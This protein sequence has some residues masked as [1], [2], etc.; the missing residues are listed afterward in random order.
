M[1]KNLLTTQS[2][3][4]NITLSNKGEKTMY[5]YEEP[6]KP[7]DTISTLTNYFISNKAQI[8]QLET[9]NELIKNRI[10]HLMRT[11][12]PIDFLACTSI[13]M[14][15]S[16]NDYIKKN[17]KRGEDGWKEARAYYKY[18]LDELHKISS[19]IA[20]IKS[21]VQECGYCYSTIAISIVFDLNDNEFELHVPMAKNLTVE[22]VFHDGYINTHANEFQLY[23][24]TSSCSIKCIWT[25]TDISKINC[26]VD[27]TKKYAL[28]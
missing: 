11:E 26:E 12:S 4:V 24:R 7:I 27:L 1:I 2:T 17:L 5:L 22:D 10:V 3:Y 18:I 28:K 14:Y 16:V 20:S 23:A 25:G 15:M 19:N 6:K 21:I 9:T 13:K 8:E